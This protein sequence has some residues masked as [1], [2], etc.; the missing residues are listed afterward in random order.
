MKHS[1][2]PI[3]GRRTR[4]RFIQRHW[5]SIRASRTCLSIM[6]ASCTIRKTSQPYFRAWISQSIPC[7]AF[8]LKSARIQPSNQAVQNQHTIA[9]F[10][11]GIRVAVA[12]RKKVFSRRLVRQAHV[13]ACLPRVQDLWLEIHIGCHTAASK[14][15]LLCLDTPRTWFC[16]YRACLQ[17]YRPP[18]HFPMAIFIRLPTYCAPATQVQ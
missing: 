1:S 17:R 8:V 10:I 16:P 11:V 5:Y 15:G 13:A 4:D 9:A 18:C 3:N 2:L 12:C 14:Q 7:S 6:V